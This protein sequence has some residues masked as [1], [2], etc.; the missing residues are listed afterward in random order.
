MTTFADFNSLI[1]L[2]EYKAI[3]QRFACVTEKGG[4]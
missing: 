1:G 4:N 2:P 3:E